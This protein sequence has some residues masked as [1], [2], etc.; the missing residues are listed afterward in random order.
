VEGKK[1]TGFF[2][3]HVDRKSRFLISRKIINK[4]ANS[5]N[6]ATISAFKNVPKEKALTLTLDNGKEFTGF[7][8]V[9]E[10]LGVCVY[11]AD[12]Y[13]SCQRGTNENTNALLRRFFP[14]GTDFTT[15]N[16]TA[17][18]KAVSSINNRP[19]KILN[20]KTPQRFI[21]S[22]QVVHLDVEFANCQLF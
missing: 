4:K 20:Y 13:C 12:P 1:G 21:T 22:E 9:E 5:F 10:S 15:L 6:E 19:R 2:V 8:K 16:N 7:K 17:L 11:F 18:Q 3:T 14:K